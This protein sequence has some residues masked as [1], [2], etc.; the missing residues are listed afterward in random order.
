MQ[1]HNPPTDIK[2]NRISFKF[3]IKALC[4]LSL[5]LIAEQKMKISYLPQQAIFFLAVNS[6][7]FT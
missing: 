4:F 6:T 5:L 7:L 2:Y 3:S 1:T